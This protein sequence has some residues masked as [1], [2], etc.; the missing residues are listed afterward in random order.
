[1][2]NEGLRVEL[3]E[4]LV[5]FI[6]REILNDAAKESSIGKAR[7]HLDCFFK[8]PF[9][10]VYEGHHHVA[11]HRMEDGIVRKNK[12]AMIYEDPIRY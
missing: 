11:L 8:A 7:Q 10:F 9:Y 2:N 5:P 6:V 4:E 1:M 12:T 3:R